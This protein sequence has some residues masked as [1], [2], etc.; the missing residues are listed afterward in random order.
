MIQKEFDLS[1]LYS[2]ESLKDKWKEWLRN[3][4][5]TLIYMNLNK[6]EEK[7]QSIRPD[8]YLAGKIRCSCLI[9]YLNYEKKSSRSINIFHLLWIKKTFNLNPKTWDSFSDGEMH[10]QW[11]NVV[12]L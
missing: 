8:M 7:E 1:P 12:R 5:I 3:N 2:F 6:N 4:Q 10:E 9:D 11:I